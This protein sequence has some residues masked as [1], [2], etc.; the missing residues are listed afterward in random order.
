MELDA[1]LRAFA[2]F[3]RRLSFS[4]A[5]QDLH[6]S[7]PAVSKH[8]ADL[9][10]TLGLKLVE[11]G[12]RG[13]ALTS[14]GEFLANYVLRAESLLAQAELGAAEFRA[15][16]SGALT[17]VAAGTIGTYLLPEII[18]AFDQAHPGVRVSLQLGTSLKT[19]EWLRSHRAELGF[20][21]GFVGAPEIEAEPLLD[22]ELVVV[23]TRRLAARRL[24]REQLES[25]TWI[26]REDGS[27]TR[28]VSD[29]AL[30][31][32]GIVPKRRLELPSWEAIKLAVMRGYGI[33]ACS[34]FA[35]EEELRM[36]LLAVIP[37]RGWK[38]RKMM[39]V[40]RVRDA[41][42]T[43]SAEQF[44]LFLRARLRQR[45]SKPNRRIRT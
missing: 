16:G 38:V 43:P 30:G 32:L 42:L 23:G 1:R 34:R 10:Q 14:A 17:I 11:R 18:A 13:G 40:I 25:L 15:P 5:A 3:A 21:G 37:V 19:V 6:I 31:N 36:G 22:D 2:A 44:L 7:Q 35:V 8:V 45:V 20:V 26:T 4:A 41:T 29:A 24:P 12:R 33:A 27:A 39:S 9:E 28:A